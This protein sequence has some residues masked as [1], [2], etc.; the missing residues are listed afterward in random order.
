[1]KEA[2]TLLAQ[3][4]ERK[5]FR[6]QYDQCVRIVLSNKPILSRILKYTVKEVKGFSLEEIEGFIDGKEISIGTTAVNPGSSNQ[7]IIGSARED[8]IEDEGRIF[9]DI[10]FPLILPNG[11]TEKI[12]INVEAQRKSNPGYSIVKR[13]IF[14]DA[15]LLSAQLGTEFMNDGSDSRQYDRLKKVYSIWICMDCPESKKDSIMSYELQPSI[16][17]DGTGKAKADY[18]Y[19][20]INVTLIH[21]SGNP[22][23]SKNQLIEMLDTLLGKMDAE[24]KKNKL[25]NKFQIPMT[26]QINQEVAKMCNLSENIWE[27]GHISGWKDGHTSGWNDGRASGWRDGHMSG[28]NDGIEEGKLTTLRDL[29]LE[30]L[31]TLSDAAKKANMTVEE[32]KAAVKL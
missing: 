1:M 13:G 24:S 27:D 14:Y 22:N 25:Q 20:L 29:V 2:G 19:D 6:I 17:Y 15:R 26:V 21:L 16:I 32:F 8:S 30:N 28:W 7:K 9:Y 23:Q 10:R 31:L 4:I 18:G 3:D 11:E 12:I 5:N